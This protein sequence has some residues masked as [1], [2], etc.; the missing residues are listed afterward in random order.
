[1]QYMRGGAYGCKDDDV[2]ISAQL[3][4]GSQAHLDSRG[5]KR[6][7]QNSEGAHHSLQCRNDGDRVDVVW[8]GPC[9]HI[10]QRRSSHGGWT[11]AIWNQAEGEPGTKKFGKAGLRTRGKR[12]NH[13][14]GKRG[15]RNY[16]LDQ[17]QP[18]F[19]G[20]EDKV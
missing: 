12:L 17:N 15:Q 16:T 5:H 18:A 13:H 20:G 10:G 2:V 7:H 6:Q 11:L 8:F 9:G 14:C 4:L 19:D 3:P 1:M